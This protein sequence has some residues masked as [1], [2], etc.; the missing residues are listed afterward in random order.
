MIEAFEIYSGG[1]RLAGVQHEITRVD[2]GVAVL[3]PHPWSYGYVPGALEFVWLRSGVLHCSWPDHVVELMPGT[4]LLLQPGVPCTLSC[5]A[6]RPVH[7]AWIEVRFASFPPR[8][9]PAVPEARALVAGGPLGALCD[10]LVWLVDDTNADGWASRINEVAA[11][12]AQTFIEGPLPTAR[13]DPSLPPPVVRVAQHVAEQ[14]AVCGPGPVTLASLANAGALSTGHLSRLFSQQV[15]LGPVAAFE[16]VRL[17][18]AAELLTRTTLSVGVIGEDCGFRDPFHFSRRFRRVF[19]LSPTAFRGSGAVATT[20]FDLPGLAAMT[21][22]VTR[23][24][25]TLRKAAVHADDSR[26]ATAGAE[27]GRR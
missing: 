8:P 14:W 23:C 13:R 22:Y 26:Q 9:W 2:G 4:L 3:P 18:Q 15:G 5:G 25:E 7:Q 10:Y 17:A 11:L 24:Q 1:A 27:V 12:L 6:G 20:A 19:G 16:R 21:E